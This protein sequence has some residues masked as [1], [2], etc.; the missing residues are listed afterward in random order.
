MNSFDFELPG[1]P[2]LVGNFTV[3]DPHTTG[4]A[5]GTSGPSCE[6]VLNQYFDPNAFAPQ[7]LGTLG[8]APRTLC[9]GPGI[10]NFDIALHKTTPLSETMHMEFRAEF[11]NI[12]NHPQFQQP[13]GNISDGSD[14][15]R[16]SRAKDPRLMQFA[17][18]LF[19]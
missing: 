8:T 1:R 2:D 11:F 16:I 7:A 6:T 10:N 3:H 18:K 17:L 9:C 19:F 13:D 14:F 4:C 15:G 5:I 12:V